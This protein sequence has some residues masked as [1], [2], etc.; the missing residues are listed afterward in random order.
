MTFKEKYCYIRR[1]F[2][3][4]FFDAMLS[5]E[6]YAC[7]AKILLLMAVVT[8]LAAPTQAQNYEPLFTN[9][10]F[11]KTINVNLP[12]GATTGEAGVSPVG[13]GTYTVPIVAPPGTNGVVPS[14]ALAYNSMGG[15]GIMGMG[16]SISGLSMISR[17]PRSIYQD[18]SAGSVELDANDRFALDG[19]RLVAKAGNYGDNGTVYATE[20]ETFA[21]ITSYNTSEVAGTG[22][23][24]VEAKDG[25]IMDYG[26]SYDGRRPFN[27][28]IPPIIWL[29]K[30]IQYP[31]GNYIEFNYTFGLDIKISEIK[32]TGNSNTGLSPYNTIKFDYTFPRTDNT[33]V[34]EAG[35]PLPTDHLLEKIT[36]T[37]ENQTVRS[38]HFSYG[39]DNINSYLR[40]IVE[41]GHDGSSLNSTIFKYGEVPNHFELGSSSVV[42]GQNVD[43]SSGDFDADGFNDIIATTKAVTGNGISY[44]TGFKIYKRTASNTSYSQVYQT[45]FPTT[46]QVVGK[47]NIPNYYN[48]LS[49]DF[50]GD[51][52]DDVAISN[53]VFNGSNRTFTSLKIYKSENS[54]TNFAEIDIPTY[55][56]Y[57]KIYSSG[58]YIFPG[59]FNGD[60]VQDML[61]MLAF[62]SSESYAS[63]IYY[64]KISTSFG[65][66]GLSG[67]YILGMNDWPSADKIYVLD[68]ST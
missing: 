47:I 29:L 7:L 14:V 48:F 5:I 56:N 63:H 66:V 10:T 61:T 54:A 46:F 36:V 17:V 26:T 24:R 53:M 30:R 58:N 27:A 57:T 68:H 9:G 64:G 1:N 3:P 52:A 33:V 22:W 6:K 15:N 32:Y 34:Y 25:T 28:I 12:V 35:A 18:G 13:G 40:E 65:T 37:T 19:M 55:P 4:N 21:R 8:F 43:V 44:N 2:S 23:F 39:F 41:K 42:V 51:G 67:S 49:T 16:W 11:N 62:G 20:N 38:Y 60:G 50:T 31:N 59:D 45:T